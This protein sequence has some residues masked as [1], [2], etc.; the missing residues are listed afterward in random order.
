MLKLGTVAKLSNSSSGKPRVPGSRATIR[1]T[2]W[3]ATVRPCA[4]SYRDAIVPPVPTITIRVVALIATPSSR[5]RRGRRVN[6]LSRCSIR[7]AAK[8]VEREQRTLDDGRV[9]VTHDEDEPRLPI[10]CGPSLEMERWVHEMLDPVDT[11]GR[12][13]AGNVENALHAEHPFTMPVEQ[14]GKP[15]AKGGP[16][17]RA[18]EY[19]MKASNVSGVPTKLAML[20]SLWLVLLG[21]PRSYISGP[22]TRIIE[23]ATEK[24][25]RPNGIVVSVRH[26]SGRIKSSE[27]RAQRLHGLG[28]R[29][30]G[31]GE[32]QTIRDC[33]LLHRFPVLRELSRTVDRVDCRNHAAEPEMMANHGIGHQRVDDRRRIRQPG[34]FDH[35]AVEPA[36]QA[37]F[38]LAIEIAQRGTYVT[39]DGTTDAAA[40]QHH[41]RGIDPTDQQMIERYLA[42]LVDQHRGI[43]HVWRAQEALQQCG[44]ATAQEA[45][46]K[47][48]GDEIGNAQPLSSL[49]SAQARQ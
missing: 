45:R 46:Q 10:R 36:A 8:P 21:E 26:L 31:L 1:S 43:S 22:V 48:D 4:G 32:N 35:R 39:A 29:Q 34:R 25:V 3:E 9:H 15:D 19:E 23:A 5:R 2:S 28:R 24:E 37:A 18:L 6:A 13:R 42:E 30:I 14:H 27:P 49:K 44:L 7:W 20:M 11:E 33:G 38:S 17:K 41:R 47:I 40:L 12:L 16:I